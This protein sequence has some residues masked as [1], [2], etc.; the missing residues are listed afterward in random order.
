MVPTGYRWFQERVDVDVA[1]FLQAQY[2]GSG[3]GSGLVPEV[4]GASTAEVP[5]VPV[6]GNLGWFRMGRPVAVETWATAS[7]CPITS[8]AF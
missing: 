4:L 8:G 2:K 5:E 1:I 3:A 6:A 7:H